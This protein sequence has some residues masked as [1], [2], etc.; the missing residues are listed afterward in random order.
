[1][2]Q[3]WARAASVLSSNSRRG[4]LLKRSWPVW[5]VLVAAL[6]LAVPFLFHAGATVHAADNEI[7]GVTLS[8]PEPGELVITWDAPSDAPDDYRVTWKKSGGKWPSY[9]NENTAQGGNAFPTGTSH[10][11]TGL[12]EGTAYSARVRARYHD[13]NGNVEQSGPWTATQEITVAQ[14][15]LPAKPTGLSASP[16]HDSVLLSWTDPS[17]NGITGYQVLRGQNTDNLA[18]L[19]ADTGSAASSYTDDSVT[20]ETTYVYAIRARNAGGLSPQ[21]DA[22]PA[23]TT[24]APPAKPIGLLT[25]ASYNNILL[26]WTD[27]ENSSITG[28]QVLR[29]DDADSLTVLVEHTV[30][31]SA[32]YTDD[33]VEPETEYF[34]AIRARNAQGLGPQSDTVSVTTQPAPPEPVE[35]VA[36]MATAAGAPTISGTPMVGQTLTADPSGIT[37][38]DGLTTPG[39]TYQWVRVDADLTENDISGATSQT[40]KLVT[41]DVGN[42]IKVVVSFTDDASESESR[43]SEPFPEHKFVVEQSDLVSNRDQGSRTHLGNGL[44]A[45]RAQGFRTGPHPHGYDISTA[46]LRFAGGSLPASR[47]SLT[48]YSSNAMDIVGGRLDIPGDELYEFVDPSTISTGFVTFTAPE[49]FHLEPNT[50]Y[51]LRLWGDGS[52]SLFPSLADTTKEDSD[53]AHGW[54]IANDHLAAL[55]G[56]SWAII[57]NR[58]VMELLG[59]ETSG[60]GPAAES[61]TV[62]S[63]PTNPT[64]YLTGDTITFALRFDESAMA[65]GDP[66]LEFDIGGAP[67]GEPHTTAPQVPARRSYSLT[68]WSAPTTTTDGID[69]GFIADAVKLD[70]DD[71]I[72][73]A[74]SNSRHLRIYP[75]RQAVGPPGQ[76]SPGH[77]VDRRDIN[78]SSPKVLRTR[79]GHQHNRHVRGAGHSDRQPRVRVLAGQRGRSQKC[80]GPIQR[81]SQHHD[82]RGLHLHGAA[83]RRG[84]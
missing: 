62:T 44:S 6:L 70:M 51:F 84:Q 32:S 21:S 45:I 63:T 77:S 72:E 35:P 9:K 8:S 59:S 37:D 10:T 16:S 27:P 38:A 40:Y 61:L 46:V 23:I 13:G 66:E 83:H 2:T 47:F 25:G 33:T 43:P 4:R 5:L 74:D 79:R 76:C 49:G 73:D 39:W 67:S 3:H 18:V 65:S 41:G 75:A 80:A 50:D 17:D 57:S 20:A 71:S 55:G 42:K 58:L 64:N 53:S 15:P 12:E 54:T 48:I 30:S 82:R 60:P 68:P 81:R 52:S 19:T 31:T 28:Y 14:T 11:V 78:P 69:I 1:M 34:Y 22:V 56:T 29:G 26:L 7:T 36:D 24:A